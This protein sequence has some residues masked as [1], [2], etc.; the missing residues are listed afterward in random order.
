MTSSQS[1][2]DF[3]FIIELVSKCHKD[4]N[5]KFW[6]QKTIENNLDYFKSILI[7]INYVYQENENHNIFYTF[8]K[9]FIELI[10]QQLITFTVNI[11][12]IDVLDDIYFKNN[13]LKSY[14][15]NS[16]VDKELKKHLLILLEPKIIDKTVKYIRNLFI[17]FRDDITKC[18]TLFK[19][20]DIIDNSVIHSKTAL[21]LYSIWKDSI[22]HKQNIDLNS[23]L[24]IEYLDYYP[25]SVFNYTP[26]T[27][28][29]TQENKFNSQT[30]LFYL[31]SFIEI[32]YWRNIN[33]A[34]DNL[35]IYMEE[36]KQNIENNKDND[37]IIKGL[38]IIL[39]RTEKS[40]S[41]IDKTTQ[42]N[43]DIEKFLT[44]LFN[45]ITSD[46][47]I[48]H[49]S[50]TLFTQ[51]L[52]CYLNYFDNKPIIKI[53]LSIRTI[54]FD[55][56]KGKNICNNKI[57]DYKLP[58][59]IKVSLF[60]ILRK[61]ICNISS[62]YTIIP[63][64]VDQDFIKSMIDYYID[65]EE[66]D[67]YERMLN[68]MYVASVS[69]HSIR[70]LNHMDLNTDLWKNTILKL[71]DS[72]GLRFIKS[73]LDEYS[74]I[75]DSMIYCINPKG[76]QNKNQYV[77]ERFNKL[78]NLVIY[79]SFINLFMNSLFAEGILSE[80]L[81][82]FEII[83]QFITLINYNLNELLGKDSKLY[84]NPFS[85][86]KDSDTPKFDKSQLI[87]DLL[88]HLFKICLKEI[89][90]TMK[91]NIRS[92]IE[93]FDPDIYKKAFI[94]VKLDPLVTERLHI[95]IEELKKIKDEKHIEWD[96]E[97]CDPFFLDPIYNPV[98]IPISRNETKD[99]DQTKIK[100]LIMEERNIRRMILN[101]GR[102]PYR[103]SLS[104]EQ[105]IEYNKLDDVK[106]EIDKF[107]SKRDEWLL[108]QG[109]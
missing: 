72:K 1:S 54:V 53:P 4:P 58:I 46:P 82:S 30:H 84:D 104:L 14:K 11:L 109:K 34:R 28:Y 7:R 35:E 45:K 77:L 12:D 95:F 32:V 73:L 8:I 51:F 102:D 68:R 86:L 93:D 103:N 6:F 70:I 79:H 83:P 85:D 65:L 2:N 108:S 96:Q 50:P 3:D 64:N 19:I 48:Y 75:L 17:G 60:E 27:I 106:K 89:D 97:F 23:D 71:D 101:E 13:Y 88:Y 9:D 99:T 105:L 56:F 67:N 61:W 24:S 55:L 47:D 16:E 33:D 57:K 10:P 40:I 49:K 26:Q 78:K 20:N 74:I 43:P 87:S 107:I 92:N 81:M 21:I 100:G 44:D 98:M 42:A 38:E 29:Q 22:I 94:G 69:N 41:L 90:E 36:V 37:Q 91:N 18:E 76:N 31:L 15:K 59:H 5:Y 62:T 25:H 63:N 52:K 66:Q 80:Y 39:K